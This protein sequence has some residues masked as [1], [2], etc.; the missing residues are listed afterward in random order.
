[1]D[2]EVVYG[3]LFSAGVII[4]VL[5]YMRST[6]SWRG[7]LAFISGALLILSPRILFELKNSFIMT[8][9]VI[10]AFGGNLH[11]GRTVPFAERIVSRAV[12]LWELWRD[13]LAL[14]NTLIGVSL[15]LLVVGTFVF[16]KKKMPSNL[17]VLYGICFTIITVAYV[18][19]L[20]F[21]KE[22]F[23]HYIVGFPVVYILL[24]GISLAV[25][26]KHVKRLQ[27]WILIVAVVVV[28][29]NL[30]PV[31]IYSELRTPIF[32]GDASVYRNQLA[33]IDYIY[34]EASGESFKYVVYTPPLHDYTY[35]YL[36]KWYGAKKYNYSPEFNYDKLSFFILEPD[37]E[38]PF[39]LTNWIAERK[40]D[41]V[42]TK[43]MEVKGG[44]VVQ[45]RVNNQ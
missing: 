14:N 19:L 40:S 27:A 30:N 10:N 44:I 41:G 42:I 34:E 29:G 24:L 35:Q 17:K 22:A 3:V 21:S 26:I 4:S 25:L 43:E 28:V 7:L 45:T 37:I 13:T 38:H 18:G 33:V 16:F 6:I 15:A 39:R 1:V 32:A 36:F 9:A 12:I 20:G 23:S 31:R 11:D 8:T 5:L 2:A